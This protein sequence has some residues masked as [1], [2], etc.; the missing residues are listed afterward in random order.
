MFMDG[1]PHTGILNEDEEDELRIFG[2]AHSWPKKILFV[3]LVVLSGGS[4]FFA[5]LLKPQIR[6][7]LTKK[8]C[9]LSKAD[10]VLLFVSITS[11]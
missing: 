10:Y 1:D 2:F 11:T 7:G 9:K 8:S 6:L 5:T 3:F 4:I